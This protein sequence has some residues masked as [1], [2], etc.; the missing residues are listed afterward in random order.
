MTDTQIFNILT[1]VQ[2]ECCYWFDVEEVADVMEH[3]VKKCQI[4]GGG[5]EYMPAL[6]EN[7]LRDF[8]T[9]KEINE[10][11]KVNLCVNIA[12]PCHA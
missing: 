7:E 6:F 9:R 2:N 3:T 10:R 12:C 11:G 1:N 8:V 4:N 5:K